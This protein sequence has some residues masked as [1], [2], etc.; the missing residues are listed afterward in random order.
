[1][2]YVVEVT[3]QQESSFDVTVEADNEEQA[4]EVAKNSVWKDEYFDDINRTLEITDEN[5]ETML[6]VCEN[7]EEEH[8][9]YDEVCPHCEHRRNEQ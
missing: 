8:S 7:C 5:Y 4:M 9:I 1:M 2:K 6:V 3:L